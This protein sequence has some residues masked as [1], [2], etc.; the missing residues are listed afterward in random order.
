ME[1]YGLYWYCLELVAQ[2]VEAHNLSFEL[3]HDAEIIANDTGIHYELVQEMMT[4]MVDLSL[5][6]R[7]EGI[8]T[9]LKLAMRTDEYTQKL[10]KGRGGVPTI[11]RQSPDKVR[12]IRTDK[13]RTIKKGH[14]VTAFD[15]FW[16]VYPKKRKKKTAVDIW[17]RKKLDPLADKLVEDIQNRLLRDKQWLKGFVPDPTTYLNGELWNDELEPVVVH[18]RRT[19]EVITEAQLKLDR[20]AADKD[21]ARLVEANA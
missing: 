16:K 1:G 19:P 8:I 13:N 18:K 6:E 10:L 5:F 21:L 17:K 14:S 15:L 11:S 2:N 20:A 9:C 7:S 3:E 4:Y 12:S